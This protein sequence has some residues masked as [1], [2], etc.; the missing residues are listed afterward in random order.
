LL[1]G[2]FCCSFESCCRGCFD[3]LHLAS[4]L[5]LAGWPA[6]PT[7]AV[8][9]GAVRLVRLRSAAFCSFDRSGMAASINLQAQ[10]SHT[11]WFPV[12]TQAAPFRP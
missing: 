5:L 6:A 8:A 12:V 2:F 1:L 10:Y 4:R 3:G 9:S 11:R 7:C